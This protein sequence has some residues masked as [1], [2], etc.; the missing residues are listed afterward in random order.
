MFFGARGR[1]FGSSSGGLGRPQKNVPPGARICGA[2]RRRR[3]AA[4]PPRPVG[5]P[6]GVRDALRTPAAADALKRNLAAFA[7]IRVVRIIERLQQVC[8]C[9]CVFQ[10]SLVPR[11]RLWTKNTSAL[12]AL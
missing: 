1:I 8:V 9:V 7:K 10:L 3:R 12:T 5:P 4:Q 2:L 6:A 11:L